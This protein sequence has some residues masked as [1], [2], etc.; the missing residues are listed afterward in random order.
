MAGHLVDNESSDQREV[1]PF[2]TLIRTY[3]YLETLSAI[4]T[5]G[6]HRLA[7]K[8]FRKNFSKSV[9]RFVKPYPSLDQALKAV[10][11]P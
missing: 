4:R 8:E 10:P 5:Y 3:S 9:N 6:Y 11:K 7:G 1:S 2:V